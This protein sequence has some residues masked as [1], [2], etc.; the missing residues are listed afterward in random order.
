MAI[1]FWSPEQFLK[2]NT[3]EIAKEGKKEKNPVRPLMVQKYA[4]PQ[5]EAEICSNWKKDHVLETQNIKGRSTSNR[6]TV[7]KNAKELLELRK[8]CEQSIKFVWAKMW[9]SGHNGAKIFLKLHHKLWSESTV[10]SR[11][12]TRLSKKY[13][14][15]TLQ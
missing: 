12:L 1:F 4:K 13:V 14:L 9:W 10:K 7:L 5:P 3:N 15:Q 8:E 2:Q 6:Q 11:G